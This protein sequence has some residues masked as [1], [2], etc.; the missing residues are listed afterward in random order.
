MAGFDPSTATAAF[1]P[2]TAAPAFDPSSA[3]PIA[4]PQAP[5]PAGATGM[6]SQ[7]GQTFQDLTD[8]N[9]PSPDPNALES[10]IMGVAFSKPV[11]SLQANYNQA[12]TNG[13]FMEPVRASM[14]ALGVGRQPGESNESLH[15]RYNQAVTSARQQAQQQAQNNTVGAYDGDPLHAAERFG[16]QAI[17]TGAGIVANPQYFLLPGMGVGGNVATRVATAG[18]GN[19]AVGSASDAA[20]QLM[21][22]AEGQKKNFDVEQNLKDTLMSG[23]FGGALHG[24][25]EVAPYVKGLFANRGMD[26]TPAQAPGQSNIQPMTGDHVAMN[27]ADHTQYQQLLATG[28]VDDIKNFFKGKQGPQPSWSDVNTWVEHRD[29]PQPQSVNGQPGAPNPEMQP[30]FNYEQEYNNHAEQQWQQSNR[31]AVEQHV[32]QQMSGWKNAPSVN[33]VHSPEDIA[34]P[35]VRDSVLKQDP[36]GDA[37]GLFGSDGQVHMFSGRITDPDTANAVLFHEGLGHNG[38]SQVFRDNLDKTMLTLADR[39]VGQF[40]KLVAERQAA[41]PGESRAL[42]AE[43][44]LA[45]KSQD[46]Q[47]HKTWQGAMDSVIRRVGSRMGFKTS[48]S[49]AEVNNILAMAHDAVINGKPDAASNGFRGVQQSQEKFMFAGPKSSH[50]DPDSA[51]AFQTPHG[52]MREE[53]SDKDARLYNIKGNTLATTLYH[54]ELFQR[55]PE[56]R[57]MR[58]NHNPDTPDLA[59]YYDS[60]TEE[61]GLNPNSFH[62][63]LHVALHETQHAIQDI[64]G[65]LDHAGTTHLSDEE[66][67]KHPMEVEAR[68]VEAR[69]GLTNEERSATPVKFMRTDQL[70][71]Q[72]KAL[73]KEEQEEWKQTGM[74]SHVRD[75]NAAVNTWD[76]FDRF[77]EQNKHLIGTDTRQVYQDLKDQDHPITQEPGARQFFRAMSDT[78]RPPNNALVRFLSRVKSRADTA[79]NVMNALHE[80][81]SPGGI[82]ENMPD[83]LQTH[84]SRRLAGDRGYGPITDDNPLNPKFMRKDAL[85][86]EQTDENQ[87]DFI[88]RLKTDPRYWSDRDYRQNVNELARTRF[89]PEGPVNKFITRAQLNRSRVAQPDY[90]SDDIESI[91]QHIEDNYTPQTM[92]R[93]EV[94]TAAIENGIKPSQLKGRDLG[95]L[96]TRVSKIGYAARYAEVQV[97]GILDKL[98]TP[99]WKPEDH[100]ALAKAI[101]RR[102]ALVE[103]FKG[104]GNELGRAMHTLKVFKEYTNGNLSDVMEQLH[105]AGSGLAQLADPT[106]PESLKFARSLKQMLQ[107]N[108]NPKGAQQM[109]NGVQKIYWEQ[110]LNTFHMNAMLSA[111]S[112]HVKAPID[113]ATG[114]T[115]NVIEKALAMPITQVRQMYERMTGRPVTPGVERAELQ[116]HMYG[117]YKAVTDMEVYRAALHAA[118]TGDS[119]Y[120]TNGQRTPTN[121]A[122]QFG[123]QSNPRIPIV[124]KATDLISAQDTIFR[125]VEMNA[126]L[127]SLG[128]RDARATLGPNA[129]SSDVYTLAHQVALNPTPTMLKEAFAQA[130][131]T[132]LLNNN[133]IN[134]IINKARTYRPG[135]NILERA[136]TFVATNLAPFIR[137]ESNNLINRV[138]QRSPL[139]LLQLMDPRSDLRAGGAKADIAWSRILYGTVLLGM[140]WAAADPAKNKLTGNGPDNVDKYKNS[141]AGGWRPNAVHENGQ[142]VTGGELG[143]SIN[144]F[145]YHNKTAQLTASARQAY[146]A[147]FSQQGWGGALKMAMGSVFSNLAGMSWVSDIQPAVDAVRAHGQ[148]GQS[149]LSSFASHEAATWVPNG[150]NQ[151][152]RLMDPNQRDTQNPNSI[153]GAIGNE[154]ASAVPGLRGNLPI[155]YSVYGTPLASGASLTGVHTMIPGLSGNGTTETVD[156]TERELDRLNNVTPDHAVVTP[157]LHSYKNDDG[158]TVHLAPAQFEE[159][160]RRAGLYTVD[161]VRQEMSTSQW[162]S[163]SDADKVQEVKYIQSDMKLKARQELFNQ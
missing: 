63:P 133:P 33:V 31:D 130:N 61:I 79:E 67:Q 11:Q 60:D 69:R 84:L 139:G 49:D 4:A 114:I 98:D 35:A 116:A 24:A 115:R 78:T 1:D 3:K 145:D 13:L 88:D 120:V 161:Q 137:V 29:G 57:E 94:R 132:L 51:T 144:P 121:F 111:L 18:V 107:S 22:M 83:W 42:S 103:M 134:N 23:V 5:R 39:N 80:A 52:E 48:Y 12:V 141:I 136:T 77:I 113:M 2:S 46:G 70:I 50:F 62:N 75:W 99:D 102:N 160:Q 150:L 122:N 38:L 20:A 124:S 126:Q 44:V 45:E 30:D 66:Y 105:E 154:M 90:K 7:I 25:V 104:E 68:E 72:F 91:A 17:N 153:S 81:K 19:A 108:A 125:S 123:S 138:I 6:F 157:V 47:M 127:L 109:M 140:Y 86:K 149:I 32:Q 135:M 10:S 96:A 26:T 43:E 158:T 14:E 53:F 106:N 89:P 117:L 112:T 163:M 148:E 131:K 118:K 36:N 9:H 162:Q 15:G 119:S 71:D 93:D 37:L 76:R 74:K 65:N 152:A 147:G 159:Y 28:S 59:G 143:M 146:E 92:T 56:L 27:A 101:A 128:A 40:G 54:P 34:D 82:I 129:L 16:Q 41:N 64:E 8:P 87:L 156:P 100:V 110:Y 55:Y 85:G 58:V 142:Y 155:K 151:A 97:K 95:E 21:D 73:P